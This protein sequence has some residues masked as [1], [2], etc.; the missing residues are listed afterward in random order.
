M[1]REDWEMGR[2]DSLFMF[3]EDWEMGRLD[4]LFKE[5]CD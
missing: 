3:R 5:D 1:F 2:L 4:S